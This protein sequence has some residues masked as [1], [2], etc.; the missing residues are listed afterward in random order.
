MLDEPGQLRLA[1]AAFRAD[2]A[3]V[4]AEFA[5]GVLLADRLGIPARQRWFAHTPGIAP[6]DSACLTLMTAPRPG[7]S[8]QELAALDSAERRFGRSGCTSLLRVEW[9]EATLAGRRPAR[10]YARDWPRLLTLAPDV[11]ALRMQYV[12]DLLSSGAAA[13]T[14]T[15]LAAARQGLRRAVEVQSRLALYGVVA[16]ILTA[17]GDPAGA[18]AVRQQRAA[19]ATH[20]RSPYLRYLDARSRWDGLADPAPYGAIDRSMAIARAHGASYRM[21]GDW[22]G[23][24]SSE[25]DA[26]DL[27]DAERVIR[28]GLALADSLDAQ[29]LRL[30]ALITLGRAELK[31]GRWQA[32][33]RTLH[34]ALPVCDSGNVYWQAEIHHNLAHAYEAGGDLARAVAEVDRFATIAN[35]MPDDGIHMISLYDAGV[36]RWEAGLHAAARMAFDSMVTVVNRRHANY[37][38]AGDYYERIG[39]LSQALAYYRREP[40][41]DTEEG[42]RALSGMARVYDALGMPDSAEAAALAHDR[43]VQTPEEVPLLPAVLAGHG[44]VRRALRISR[45]WADTQVERGNLRGAVE[46]ELQLAALLLDANAAADASNEAVHAG[47]LAVRAN[48]PEERARAMTLEAG[49]ELR[50]GRVAEAVHEARIATREARDQGTLAD[51]RDAESG[52]GDALAASGDVGG[53]LVAYDG[54]ARAIEAM[55]RS[56]R[57]E[58]TVARFHA[59]QLDVF[60]KAVTLVLAMPPSARRTAELLAWSE[61]RNSAAFPGAAPQRPPL[62]VAAI[63]RRLGAHRALVEYVVLHRASA[64]VVVT[65]SRAVV[66]SLDAGAAEIAALVDSVRHPFTTVYLGRIDLARAV[67]DTST[68]ATLAR[69][70]LRPVEPYLARYSRITIVPDGAMHLLPFDLLPLD[71][72]TLA[73]DRYAVSLLPSVR[74]LSTPEAPP[75]RGAASLLLVEGDAPGALREIAGVRGVWRA[76]PVRVLSQRAATETAIRRAL[77]GYAILHFAAHAVVDAADPLASHL[78]LAPDSTSDG[79]FHLSEIEQTRSHARLV[80]LSACESEN[81]E[82]F[83]GVGPIGLAR[84]FLVG[85]AQAVVA[86]QWPVTAAEAPLMQA[87]YT[88]LAAGDAVDE[89]LRSAKETMRHDPRTSNPIDWAGVVAVGAAAERLGERR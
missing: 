17:R 14:D 53:A 66:V 52:F 67:L 30:R 75:A 1:E 2:P 63:R 61:R 88:R 7:A 36:I 6:A 12:D 65:R 22:L 62:D 84:A 69:L 32:A 60:T 16:H 15:A 50:L 42:A 9:E 57:A 21:A 13:D 20:H 26:G 49:A 74:F 68:A 82:S 44:H 40:R 34:L 4:P 41:T 43:E 27:L 25:L 56:V 3:Y 54:A 71:D 5:V 33:V 8:T 70:V 28:R 64:A 55:S 19:W 38:Y 89:A 48:V 29:P 47:A 80:V 76:G 73:V 85:G 11:G 79:L 37:F 24:G 18:A 87:F 31:R 51:R 81:G 78:V 39:H 83:S 35:A 72:S 10:L 77:P 86:T 59:R 45:A 23:L 58:V 46:A